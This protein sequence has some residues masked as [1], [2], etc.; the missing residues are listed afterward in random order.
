MSEQKLKPVDFDVLIE[1][2]VFVQNPNNEWGTL[3]E[4]SAISVF[5]L[6]DHRYQPSEER[7]YEKSNFEEGF[8]DKLIEAGFDILTNSKC[9]GF[10][11]LREGYC[12]PWETQEKI[13]RDEYKLAIWRA[14]TQEK[15]DNL[16]LVRQRDSLRDLLTIAMHMVDRECAD[17]LRRQAQMMG[18]SLTEEK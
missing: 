12:W 2:G 18:V 5:E 9:F 6:E 3:T 16:S 15:D 4:H 13:N 11:G 17:I 1:S 10:N 8:V 7:W 14:I